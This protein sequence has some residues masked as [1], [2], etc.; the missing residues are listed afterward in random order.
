MISKYLP[1]FPSTKRYARLH[2]PYSGSLGSRF[3]TF[4]AFQLLS[5]RYYDPLRL[6]LLRLGSLRIPLD[7]RYLALSCFRSFRFP[8]GGDH[9]SA[10]GLLVY[11]FACTGVLR[12]EMAVLSSSQAT[13]VRTCPARRPRWCPLDSPWRLQDSCLPS[14]P[15]RRLSPALAGLSFRTTNIQFS[16]LSHAAYTLATPGFTHT[17]LAMHAGSLQSRRLTFSGGN[18]AVACPHPLGNIIQFHKLLFGPMDLN[19][20]RHE[21]QFFR[22][23]KRLDRKRSGNHSLTKTLTTMF[24]Q[25]PLVKNLENPQYMEIILNGKATLAERFAEVDV[26]QVR[27][28][29]AEEQKVTKKY[30]KRMAEVFKITHLPKRLA[31]ILPKK[32]SCSKSNRLL[33]Q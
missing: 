18:W 28:L 11:R 22:Y 30:P 10:P 31:M 7:S 6:P 8:G 19:L 3:P 29:F 23:L 2:L 14:T 4:T 32:A 12:K 20:T 21:E 26:D 27:K 5:H 33:R 13:P 25:T 17:L 24:A 15:E 9:P 1:Y 16:G